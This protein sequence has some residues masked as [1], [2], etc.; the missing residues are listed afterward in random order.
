MNYPK[1]PPHVKFLTK[2][3]LGGVSKTGEVER[4]KFEVLGAWKEEYTIEAILTGLLKLMSL[5]ANKK[6]A[7][8]AEGTTY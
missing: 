5:P 7:Q 2:I 3:N 8:P 4:D 1:E 6:L